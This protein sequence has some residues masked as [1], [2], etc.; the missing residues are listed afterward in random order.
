MS[1]EPMTD[2]EIDENLRQV[3]RKL[4]VKATHGVHISF[5]DEAQE[6]ITSMAI[7]RNVQVV[8]LIRHYIFAGLKSDETLLSLEDVEIPRVDGVDW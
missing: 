7:K 5:S 8:Q 3:F 4:S 1:E 6:R 2:E